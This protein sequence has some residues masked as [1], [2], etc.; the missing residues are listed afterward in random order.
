[1]NQTVI[2]A[3]FG[4]AAPV[5]GFVGWYL[6]DRRKSRA[7]SE[8][9]ERTVDADVELKDVAVQETHL[10]YVERTFTLER[11]SLLR[12]VSSLTAENAGLRAD[13]ATR[14]ELVQHLR[15]KVAEMQDQLAHLSRQTVD[16]RA[17][18]DA[19]ISRPAE[20]EQA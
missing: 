18:L 14:D 12:Q 10:A 7:E 17:Q 4:C 5:A 20:E 9:A 3:L 11:E 8:V 15:A 16:L 19:L 1:M 2:E 13:L 6:R